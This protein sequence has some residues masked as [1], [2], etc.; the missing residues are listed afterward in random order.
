MTEGECIK[1]IFYRKSKDSNCIYRCIIK[2]GVL[3]VANRDR[4]FPGCCEDYL[5]G[6]V[7][8]LTLK[9]KWFI[10]IAEG[11]KKEEYRKM[12]CYWI[13]RLCKYYEVFPVGDEFELEY[14]PNE[15]DYI[16][17]T[18]GYGY[19]N[20]WMLITFEDLDYEF[21]P[22][23][24]IIGLGDIITIQNYDKIKQSEIK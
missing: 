13:N 7:L 3:P 14:E 6:K 9:R 21:G 5:K 8:H 19:H 17:F 24:F 1:C 18:N 16:L 15:F 23:R 22:N 4:A 20:P 10:E 12:N 2:N 11:R